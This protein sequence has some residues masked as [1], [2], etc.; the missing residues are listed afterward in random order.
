[1]LS[2]DPPQC[3]PGLLERAAGHR[4]VRTIIAG[5]DSA[6]AMESALAA[7]EAGLIEPVFVGHGPVILERAG[8]LG[9]DIGAFDRHEA[10]GEHGVAA[11]AAR[12]AGAGAG[13]AVMKGNLHTDIFMAA[14]LTREAGI[15]TG[16]RMTHAFHMSV[17]GF[18]RA[19]IIAD[20][21]LNVAP[22][23]DTKQAIIENSI[24]LARAAGVPAP[25]VALLSASETVSERMPSSADA[26]ALSDWAGAHLSGARVFGPLA[27][28]TIVSRQAAQI[29]GIDHPVAGETDIVVVPNIEC[30]NALFKMMVYFLGACAG[31]LVLGGR[32]PVMLTSRADPP[33]ARLASAALA[34]LVANAGQSA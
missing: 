8:E 9:W 14:L 29:K 24:D 19:L 12:L 32:I 25:N 7:A 2:P 34:V 1:M 11:E 15:R 16:R 30:G 6:M 3:P 21:A 20:A 17:G 10:A 23:I 33:A 27:F 18:E 31:G 28:D 13:Q 26:A 22:D 5:A 4:P